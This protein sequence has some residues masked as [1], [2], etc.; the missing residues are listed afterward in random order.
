MRPRSQPSRAATFA[1]GCF[2]V[3]FGLFW[4]TV[5][6]GFDGVLAYNAFRQV[7]AG[8]A[9]ATTTGQ[10]TSSEVTKK[11]QRRSTSYGIRIAY[12]YTVAGINYTGT[13]F[14]Y[15]LDNNSGREWAAQ[16]VREHPPGAQ[17]TVYYH[18]ERP[19]EAVLKPG[20][21]GSDLF[22]A[23]FV[24]P[25]NL[26]MIAI[27]WMAW[28]ALRKAPDD[29]AIAGV[30]LIRQPGPLRARLPHLNGP[31]TG[32]VTLGAGAF[33]TIFI[34]AFTAGPRISLLAMAV[35]WLVLLSLA[36]AAGIW[37]A[38][39]QSAGAYDL[40]VDPLART[41]SLPATEGRKA[42]RVIRWSDIGAVENRHTLLR[43]GSRSYTVVLQIKDAGKP[44]EIVMTA[45]DEKD[46]ERFTQWLQEVT[47][48]N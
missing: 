39:K 44:E 30:P 10:I 1:G 23:L 13:R 9:Y 37:V 24:T 16:A 41:V 5:V 26:I 2:L 25:F 3:V 14:R 48:R 47:G 36:A 21:E 46:A 27:W 7:Q 17:K 45:R 18:P 29:C 11:R 12:G 40:L 33:V 28:A 34:V 8:T 43:K 22:F 19:D 4:T 38:W 15:G 32:F 35:V 42:R 6:L 31:A 20:L